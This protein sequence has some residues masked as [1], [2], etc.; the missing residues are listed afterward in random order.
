MT[1]NFDRRKSAAVKAMVVAAVA[2]FFH[3]PAH[4]FSADTNVTLRL[5]LLNVEVR[6]NTVTLR[7]ELT[8]GLP[9]PVRFSGFSLSA[10]AFRVDLAGSD[11]KR[12]QF[13]APRMIED[14]PS[15]QFDYHQVI[16]PRKTATIIVEDDRSLV[17]VGNAGKS[18]H[19]KTLNYVLQEDLGICSVDFKKSRNVKLAGKGTVSITWK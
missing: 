4:A 17:P 3:L 6:S 10:C 16:A 13:T 7:V 9:A 14:P 11:G 8:N 18:I 15:F 1:K 12:W 2:F 5:T 19:P